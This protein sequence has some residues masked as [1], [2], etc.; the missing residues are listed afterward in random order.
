LTSNVERELFK[1]KA[2]YSTDALLQDVLDAIMEVDGEK[3]KDNED[4]IIYY[5]SNKM[6]TINIPDIPPLD[7]NFMISYDKNF[8]FIF[9]LKSITS[10]E[11]KGKIL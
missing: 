7:L 8:G 5:F 2:L 10:I 6:S 1:K 3:Q 11:D 9:N 4:D